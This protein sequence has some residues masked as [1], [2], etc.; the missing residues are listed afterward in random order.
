MPMSRSSRQAGHL[1]FCHGAAEVGEC[2]FFFSLETE[3]I[4]YFY[5]DYYFVISRRGLWKINRKQTLGEGFY[6]IITDDK[7]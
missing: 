2:R 5:L 1:P 3:N 7:I 4:N 6:S